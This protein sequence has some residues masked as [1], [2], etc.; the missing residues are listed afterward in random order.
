MPV[1]NTENSAVA[2]AYHEEHV[3]EFQEL[4]PTEVSPFKNKHSP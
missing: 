1:L 2:A 3:E 4:I